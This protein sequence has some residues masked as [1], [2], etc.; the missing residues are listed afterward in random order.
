VRALPDVDAVQQV[1]GA[2]GD[3]VDLAENVRPS[4]ESLTSWGIAPRRR[5][6]VLTTRSR[7][8]STTIMRAANSHETS[9]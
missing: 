6:I 5:A 3:R 9:A 7:R 2:G 4:G 8:R 1:P